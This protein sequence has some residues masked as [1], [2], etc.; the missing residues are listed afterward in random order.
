MAN[1]WRS[2]VTYKAGDKVTYE[3]KEYE[4]ITGHAAQIDW[5]PDIVAALWKECGEAPVEKKEEE[6]VEETA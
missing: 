5:C 1:Q 3:G 6:K 4:C 2:G